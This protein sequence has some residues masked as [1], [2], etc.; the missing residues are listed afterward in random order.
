MMWLF[1]H[2][3]G[4]EEYSALHKMR[5]MHSVTLSKACKI[6]INCL[7]SE[8]HLNSG[9]LEHYMECL[10]FLLQ[11][12]KRNR[13]QYCLP[14]KIVSYEEL[15]GWTMDAIVKEIGLKNNCWYS[16]VVFPYI[17]GC[18]S[19]DFHVSLLQV[20]SVVYSE[21]RHWIVVPCLQIATRLSLV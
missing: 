16:L 4:Q 13:D 1:E 10:S 19:T 7:F 20:H 12:V 6:L 17:W 21:G 8:G 9:S 14:L 15:Y 5:Q 18:S 2:P 11:T 3:L